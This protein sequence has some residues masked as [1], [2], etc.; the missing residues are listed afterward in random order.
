MLVAVSR[1]VSH[2]DHPGKCRAAS[3]TGKQGTKISLF[4][5][6]T[7]LTTSGPRLTGCHSQLGPLHTVRD[8]TDCSKQVPLLLFAGTPYMPSDNHHRHPFHDDFSPLRPD[9][10]L[11]SISL[12]ARCA[13]VCYNDGDPTEQPIRVPPQRPNRRHRPCSLPWPRAAPNVNIHPLLLLFSPHSLRATDLLGLHARLPF[14][15]PPPPCH[16]RCPIASQA[17]MTSQPR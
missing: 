1:W 13:R 2:W 14:L 6:P 15:P 12:S 16:C 17:S 9:L 8:L 7:A 4:L 11:Q 5:L 10:V 3:A